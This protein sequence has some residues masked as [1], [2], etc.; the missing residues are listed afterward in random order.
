MRHRILILAALLA[1][2]GCR[3]NIDLPAFAG[4]DDIRLESGGVTMF[5]YDSLTCQLGFNR[6]SRTFRVHTDSMTDFFE[7]TLSALPSGEGDKVEGDI[8][9]TTKRDIST[10]KNVALQTIRAEGD[11][12]WLWNEDEDIALVVRFLD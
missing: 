6:E 3:E 10:I 5:C 7:V 11:R 8:T 4:R 9:W 1:L 2:A 12:I